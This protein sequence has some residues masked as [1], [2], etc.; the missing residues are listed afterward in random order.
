MPNYTEKLNHFKYDVLADANST[1]NITNA[2]N[3]NWDKIDSGVA[4]VDLSN[5]SST[6]QAKFDAKANDNAVV[7]KAG[8]E[9]I[10]GTKTFSSTISITNNSSIAIKPSSTSGFYGIIH[11]TPDYQFGTALQAKKY[12][13]RVL[14]NAM[15]NSDYYY[16][17]QVTAEPTYNQNYSSIRTK[18]DSNIKEHSTVLKVNHSDGT[19]GFYVNG[20]RH[21]ALGMP[22]NKY[23]A[24]TLGAS[25]TTYT[26]P[27]DGWFSIGKRNG[28]TTQGLYIALINTSAANMT[29][30]YRATIYDLSY[31]RIYMPAKAGDKVRVEYDMV[32][33]TEFFNF[34]YAEGSKIL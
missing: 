30:E 20:V 6:G 12:G 23:K 7:H 11:T 4:N 3:N 19:G 33:E 16:T 15:D 25:G 34:I 5:L 2:L 29:S 28:S 9:T 26:A 10:T 13:M 22:S 1:F 24:L 32:G 18:V 27:A 31:G 17:S 21:S 8:T 14:C